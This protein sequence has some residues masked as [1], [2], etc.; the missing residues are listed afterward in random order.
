MHSLRILNSTPHELKS[1]TFGLK[2][3]PNTKDEILKLVSSQYAHYELYQLEMID[4]VIRRM[5]Y[6]S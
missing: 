3:S 4:G 6:T 1:I 5:E 2:I